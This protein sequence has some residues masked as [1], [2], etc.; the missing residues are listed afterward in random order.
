MSLATEILD[1]A[2][3]ALSH[4][5]S[6]GEWQELLERVALAEAKAEKWNLIEKMLRKFGVI[7]LRAKSVGGGY[8][9]STTGNQY[10]KINR[11]RGDTPEEAF[12][13]AL[14]GKE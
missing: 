8:L 5:V 11:F 10:D 4:N 3:R 6:D 7:D 1:A 2:D 12:T 9:C 13:R 14:E